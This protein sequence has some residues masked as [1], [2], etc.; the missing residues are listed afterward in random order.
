[1]V[2]TSVLVF[3]TRAWLTVDGV[4]PHPA[5]SIRL[6]L[7]GAE[8]GGHAHGSEWA[9]AA[10]WV[11]LPTEGRAAHRPPCP[12]SVL[13]RHVTR[14]RVRCNSIRVQ[15]AKI[16]QKNQSGCTPAGARDS[17]TEQGEP[18]AWWSFVRV[19][20]GC[21]RAWKSARPGRSSCRKRKAER[22][23]ESQKLHRSTCSF[24]CVS[25]HPTRE[26]ILESEWRRGHTLAFLFQ[27]A[28]GSRNMSMSIHCCQQ[29][30]G[31]HTP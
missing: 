13:T 31:A 10:K 21:A 14:A 29:H 18:A 11:P 26:V 17:Q 25:T 28:A 23:R 19:R 9:G 20:G 6:R 22:E 8:G 5:A 3:L 12:R 2:N 7:E 1:M 24:S 4:P 16:K 30:I 15:A 27:A